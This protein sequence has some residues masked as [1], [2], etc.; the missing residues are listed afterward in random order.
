M[1]SMLSWTEGAETPEN[2]RE[3]GAA[4]AALAGG[5]FK[6]LHGI[7]FLA[8]FQLC[9]V[10]SSSTS[11]ENS[12]LGV[13]GSLASSGGN[14]SSAEGLGSKGGKALGG[15][16]CPPPPCPMG[17]LGLGIPF[18]GQEWAEICT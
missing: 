15:W 18:L 7:A 8:T 10:F 2:P 3:A 4:L 12:G 14:A 1:G 5:C 9:L 11:H 17:L 16:V 6:P 13:E